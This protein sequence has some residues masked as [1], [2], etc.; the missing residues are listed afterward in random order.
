MREKKGK[1]QKE[2]V[3]RF[4][5][6]SLLF[7]IIFLSCFGLVMVYSTSSYTAMLDYG[8][9]FYFAK[10]Q[11]IIMLVSFFGMLGISKI[12]YHIF[13]KFAPLAYFL[14]Y[15]LMILVNYVPGFGKAVNGKK[16]WLMI[17]GRSLFQPS[18]LV[19]VTIIL[20]MACFI[21]KVGRKIDKLLSLFVICVMVVPLA[22]LVLD[23]NLSTGIIILG[24]AF[25]MYFV[26]SRRKAAF[27]ILTAAGIALVF[28]FIELAPKLLEW[29]ILEEYQLSRIVVW[30]DPES[31]ALTGGHQVL[32]GLYAIGSGGLFGKGLGNSIQKLGFVPEAQNDMIFSIICE[33]LGL[34]G[35]FLVIL[36]FS[37]L[38]WRL[39]IIANNAPDMTGSL[40]VTGVLAHI[41]IQVIFNLAV[42]TNLMPNTGVSLPF[43]SSGGSSVVCLMA[44]IGLVLSVSGQIRLSD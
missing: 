39:M 7:V 37:I 4:Y 14:C 1:P 42:A 36:L 27:A 35:A 6:Y 23:N 34:F 38:I 28:A 32:Q 41:A 21:V 15:V 16:R 43:I 18:E 22:Y 13:P 3:Q 30:Q 31:Y 8:D 26:A 44:E 12:N 20:V 17:A 33:E 25:V 29:G 10:R 24:I 5:D 11:G 2:N 19:K 40:M 9:S